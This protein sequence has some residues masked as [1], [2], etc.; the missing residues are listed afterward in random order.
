MT[1]GSFTGANHLCVVTA[2]LDAAVRAWSDGYG[3]GPWTIYDEGR[4]EHVGRGGRRA[5]AVRDARALCTLSPGFRLELIQPLE[6]RARTPSRSSGRAVV[7]TCTI[8]G[9]RWTTTTSPARRLTARGLEIPLDA[10]FDGAPGAESKAA[11]TYFDTRV[12][13]GFTLE[14]ARSLR[15]RDAGAGARG[16]GARPSPGG[17]GMSQTVE[18]RPRP[19]GVTLDPG[20]ERRYRERTPRSFELLERTRPLI[21]TGHGG[22]MWY[23]LPYPVLL[24]HGKGCRV[25]DVDGNEYLDLRI[26]DWVMILGHANERVRDAVVAQLDKGMQF[27]SADWDLSHRMAILLVERMPS[28]E[29]IRFLV[30]GTEANL[31]A[32]RLARAFTGRTAVAKTEGSYH[33]HAD[34]MVVGSSTVGIAPDRVPAGV[35]PQRHPGA[36]EIP[37]NDPDG[38]EAILEREHESVAAVLIEPVQGAAGMIAAS[39]EYLQRLRDV[40]ARLGIVL[41]FDEVVTFPVAYGG[42]QAVHRVTPDL[43]TMSKAIGG[44]LPMSAVGGRSEIMDLLDPELHGGVAPVASVSTFACNQAS[45]AAGI[46]CLEQLTPEVHARVQAIG[47]RARS[48]I[49][50]LGRSYDIPLH[51]TGSRPPVRDA[52]GAGA[53]R[54]LPDPDAGRPREDRQP[55][56]RAHERWLLPDVT[57]LLPAQHRGRRDRDRRLP[58]HARASAP[59]PRVRRVS[60]R[61]LEGRMAVVTGGGS[62]IGEAICVR[63]AADGARVAVL[64]VSLEAAELTATLVG[65]AAV[66]ADVADAA[67]VD[68][69]LAEAEAALGPVDVWVNNA[70]IAAVAHAARIA[71]RS[72]RQLEEAAT[73]EVTTPLESLVRLPDE[74]WR[75]MLAVHLDGTF[76]GTR[77]AARS[78]GFRGTGAIVNVSSICGLEGCVGHPHY[79]AAKAGILGFTRAV[80]KELIVQGIRVNAVAPG[81]VET[82]TEALSESQRAVIAGRTPIGRHGR[83]DEIAATVAFLASDDASFFVGETVSPNGGIVTI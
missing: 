37:F 4:L 49:D 64:D 61:S 51:S 1:D 42:A 22:G 44:G 20:E 56:S 28:V 80:A 30:S 27:G 68:A 77:A 39:T 59:H 60:G 69:A 55:P 52:L 83:P 11:A 62:G 31:L 6:G 7:I 19:E 76:H 36:H 53:R 41:I 2:D 47:D 45:L 43:T 38:A 46:A 8:S 48:G 23:Q 66:H 12:E 73:G 40:T 81:F 78:M 82:G 14:I 17:R 65:G 3:I 35:F 79:S 71:D 21:P 25:W 18:I 54:R 50:E 70:G 34:L 9:S 75:R 74:E 33:G 26:G 32:V 57:R 5:G 13:L 16:P 15:V 24:T 67:S 29:R 63:L 58:R 10:S 72:R